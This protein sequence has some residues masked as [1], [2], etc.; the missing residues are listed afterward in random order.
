MISRAAVGALVIGASFCAASAS[1]QLLPVL[2][3]TPEGVVVDAG[4]VPALQPGARMSFRRADGGAAEIAQGFVLDVRESRA[5]V[6]LR[7]GSA[8]KAGD[9]AIACASLAGPGSQADLRANVQALKA[10]LTASGGGSPDVQ[11]AV[12]Q[13]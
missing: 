9:V 1:A 6:G 12:A 3:T 10:Q 7:P 2:G 5:L 8:V 4:A 11:V 13:L